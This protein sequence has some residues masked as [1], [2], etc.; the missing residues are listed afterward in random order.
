[1]CG[2][3]LMRYVFIQQPKK[4]HSIFSREAQ[5]KLQ[6]ISVTS[7]FWICSCKNTVI[8]P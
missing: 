1:M 5:S 8:I 6:N 3:L 4:L 2:P 7:W